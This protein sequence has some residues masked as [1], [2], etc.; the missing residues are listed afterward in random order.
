MKNF[1][2]VTGK[3]RCLNAPVLGSWRCLNMKNKVTLFAVIAVI[4]LAVMSSVSAGFLY[5]PVHSAVLL[6]CGEPLVKEIFLTEKITK[7]DA[8][9]AGILE[10]KSIDTRIPQTRGVEVK[11]GERVYKCTLK[12]A[13]TIPPSAV[14][15]DIVG[16]PWEKFSADEFVT[17]VSDMTEV[18]AAFETE[19]DFTKPGVQNLMVILSDTSGNMTKI[20]VTLTVPD[21]QQNIKISCGTKEIKIS[22]FI[23]GEIPGSADIHFAQPPD[24]KVFEKLGITTLNIVIDGRES[25]VTFEIVDNQPPTA[26]SK[27]MQLYYP[28]KCKISDF[29]TDLYDFT[30]A[31]TKYVEEPD[32]TFEGEQEVSVKLTDTSGNSAVIKSKLLIK[33][34]KTP[35]E[36]VPNDMTLWLGDVC[37]AEEFCKD[38]YDETPP[39]SVA[40]LSEPDWSLTGTQNVTIALTDTRDNSSQL[41]AKLTLMK[42]TMPPVINGAK[43]ITVYAGDSIDYLAGVW[44]ED[45]RDG[46]IS[47]SYSG[48]PPN[49]EIPGNYTVTYTSKDK[50]GNKS[51]ESVT[52]AILERPVY[53]SSGSGAII[54]NTDILNANFQKIESGQTGLN[55][56]YI[57]VN[58]ALCTVTVYTF[59]SGGNY[60][61][62]VRA[63]LCSPGTSETPTVTGTFSV[64]YKWRWLNMGV[65]AQY[66]T[67]FYGDYLFHSTLYWEANAN[68]LLSDDYNMLG[69]PASHGCVRLCVTDAKW[70]YDNCSYGTAVTIEN[71]YSSPGPLGRPDPIRVS[72][73]TDRDPTDIWG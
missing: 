38:I 41:T 70:M 6:E 68:T 30:K 67:Q 63:M 12:I 17:S 49:T 8:E 54:A 71:D 2:M 32:W 43:N 65:W 7:S 27:N 60:T 18:T 5:L 73:G 33:Y 58:P 13:D 57:T 66:V 51:S 24:K 14:S 59:D 35:P 56:Y 25:E 55:P 62:P 64:A 29:Y 31:D 53:T 10:L 15:V 1:M 16:L 28:D 21:A 4:L 44:A 69:L 23:N 26:K 34:D 37:S 36:A 19:P 39:V 9:I 42:D 61:V 47:V 20:P 11:I 48:D 22:D 52:L 50:S 72:P 40:F 3:L 46:N 45:N